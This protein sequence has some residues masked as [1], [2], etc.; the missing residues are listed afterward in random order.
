[1]AGLCL[2]GEE[3]YGEALPYFEH[4]LT[5]NP[6]DPVA[7]ANQAG[8]LLNLGRTA[9]AEAAYRQAVALDPAAPEAVAHLARLLRERGDFAGAV[10]VIDGALSAGG[11][12]DPRWSLER[13]LAYAAAGRL[14]AALADFLAAASADEHLPAG[15]AGSAGDLVP[16]ALENA[17][18][19]AYQLRRFPQAAGL[20]RRLADLDPARPGPWKTLGAI[21]LYDLHDPAAARASFQRAL[22]VE[23]DAAERAQIEGLLAELPK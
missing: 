21:Q 4:A 22:A 5:V 6:D 17:A 16:A 10:E 15:D 13:G 23:T 7:R 12:R 11:D 18:Q 9:D 2:M 8:C 20:Y 19:A 14:E 3:K 1:M